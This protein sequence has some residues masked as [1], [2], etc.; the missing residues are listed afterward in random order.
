MSP[1]QAR[2]KCYVDVYEETNQLAN[3]A[4]ELKPPQLIAAILE[5]FHAQE[6]LSDN[7]QAYLLV[8]KETG[9][10]LDD[11]TPL[12]RQLH[13]LDR[14]ALVE[15][16]QP[17]PAGAAR[18]ARP[19][20]L[21]ELRTPRTFAVPWL[22]AIIGRLSEHQPHNE[23]VAVDLRAYPAGLRVSRRH[24]RLTE[25]DGRY[26]IENLSNNPV[27]LVTPGQA[28]P[29]AVGPNPVPIA[30]GDVIC[31]DRSDIELKLIVR[32]APV[33][34]AANGAA[35]VAP[36]EAAEVASDADADSAQ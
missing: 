17:L 9:Q 2:I 36:V 21:R 3:A 16:T 14:L 22:P 15:R 19:V 31:L 34:V 11:E 24:A 25:L 13:D 12:G 27:S 28:A 1:Q 30:P 5:E 35:T 29:V 23:L 18:P 7:P 32:D 26:Y 6:Q 10:P 33:A 4:S 8:N 20:Y